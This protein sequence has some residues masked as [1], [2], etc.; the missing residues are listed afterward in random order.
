MAKGDERFGG[1]V[2][3]VLDGSLP[4]CITSDSFYNA[5]ESKRV[6][7]VDDKDSAEQEPG[8]DEEEEESKPVVHLHEGWYCAVVVSNDK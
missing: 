8:E 4:I 3:F 1:G 6:L 5:L 7:P 2:R